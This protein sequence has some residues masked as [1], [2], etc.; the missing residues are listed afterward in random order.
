VGVSG[1]R[2]LWDDFAVGDR[3]E[4][5][6]RTVTETDIVFWSALVGDWNPAHVDVE[7]AKK[8][9]F[10]QRIAHG[11]IA[12]NLS[13]A[14]A[15]R[16]APGLYR[17]PGYVRLLGWEGVRFTAPI[18][19]GDTIRAERTLVSLEDGEKGCGVLVYEVRVLKQGDELAM[20]G[21]ERLLVRKRGGASVGTDDD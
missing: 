9:P 4:T 3:I 5:D 8:T 12:F 19:I 7:H 10:G 16:C 1:K 20:I 13:V 6:A 2:E 14:L 11:N 18:F 17:P 15:A 21:K